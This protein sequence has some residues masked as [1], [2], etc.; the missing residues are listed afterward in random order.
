MM[1]ARAGLP[2][3]AFFTVKGISMLPLAELSKFR[4]MFITPC[5]GEV[6][7]RNF[8]KSMMELQNALWRHSLS[9]TI[10]IRPGDSLVTRARNEATA[11]F[12]ADKTATH[13]FWIDSDVGFTAEQV[14]RL[15]LADRDVVAGAYPIKRFEWPAQL[16]AGTTRESFNASCLRYPVNAANGSETMDR[17]IDE[18]G[19][20]EVSE[21][22]T[23]FMVIKRE[24]FVRM[25]QQLPGLQY[26]PDGLPTLPHRDLFYRFFD[27]LVDP[28]TGRYLS[29]DYAFCRRWRDLGG[30]VFIDARAKLSHQ[31]L[32]LY[33]GDFAQTLQVAPHHAIG[34]I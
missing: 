13:L 18:D 19:F 12:L 9:A 3:L 1:I 7:S 21:A 25:M 20:I 15:L 11:I 17:T 26:T 33:E 14:F 23:G 4:P 29:E 5:Y 8:I 32:H 24:V 34:G 16:P 31:G 27:V 30:K 22:P 6:V 28:D 10:E 2:A